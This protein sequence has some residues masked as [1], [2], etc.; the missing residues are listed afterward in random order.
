MNQKYQWQDPVILNADG[1]KYVVYLTS[2]LDTTGKPYPAKLGIEQQYR[3]AKTGQNARQV[4]RLHPSI[5]ATVELFAREGQRI[6]N[7]IRMGI[8]KLLPVGGSA[9]IPGVIT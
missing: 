2:D 7:D 8:V 9:P 5:L 1:S 3:D 6:N 4:V